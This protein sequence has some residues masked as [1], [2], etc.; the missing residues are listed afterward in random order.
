MHIETI[1]IENLR[2]IAN[3]E[4]SPH[5]KINIIVGCNGAGKT[6]LLE[7][8][9]LL[10]RARSFRQ[11]KTGRLIREGEEHLN[12]FTSLQTAT[13]NRHHIGLRKTVSGTLIRKDGENLKK[14]SDLAKSIPLSII[15]PN[16]QR[17]IEDDPKNRRRLLNWGMFHV[18]HE[19]ANLVNRYKKAL[20]Q[21]NNAL[22]GS[23]EQ[24]KVWDR[25]LIQLGNE[26]DRRMSEYTKSWNETVNTI[27]D[28]TGLIKPISLKVKQGWKEEFTLAEA[29]DRNSKIDKE[30][31]F[32]SCGPHRSDLKILQDGKPIKNI[33]SRGETKIAAAI[34]L[35]SQTKILEDR[36]GESPVLLVDDLHSELD[37]ERY[38]N[39]LKL[40]EDMN[41]QSFVTTLDSDRSK[42]LI[43][44]DA[45]QMFHVEHGDISFLY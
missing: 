37:S 39:L 20:I 40:I 14:R 42:N 33:F 24:I 28:V 17:I 15:T 6:T 5:K 23:R 25:Q 35:L 38:A 31:G 10:A 26:I 2:N 18:E 21:R 1:K 7:S 44:A 8:I 3:A 27:I 16:I 30:R 9:Y 45:C 41:V 13:N 22:R 43:S 32:T 11:Q 12:L 19:Y 36:T 34:M 29:L 4:L